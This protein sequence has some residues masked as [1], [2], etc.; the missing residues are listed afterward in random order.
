MAISEGAAPN[1]TI[2]TKCIESISHVGYASEYI[3]KLVSGLDINQS[4]IGCTQTVRH[5]SSFTSFVYS[6]LRLREVLRLK[7]TELCDGNCHRNKTIISL[8]NGIESLHRKSSHVHVS[9]P[10]KQ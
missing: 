8:S 9:V 4:Y 6:G 5:V 7:P 2:T 1:V 3:S 10:T